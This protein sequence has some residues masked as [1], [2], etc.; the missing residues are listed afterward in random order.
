MYH[1]YA[2]YLTPSGALAKTG[3]TWLGWDIV[4]GCTVPHPVVDDLDIAAMT[5][6]PR[7]YGLHATIKPPMVLAKGRTEAE[8]ILAARDIAETLPQV[9]LKGLRV[10]R[11]GS[12]LAL[13][14]Q[15]ETDGVTQLAAH[16]VERLDPFRDPLRPEDIARR[17]Q[18]HLTASQDQNLMKW[19]YPHVMEDFRFHI[20]LTGPLRNA[21]AMIPVV[22]AHFSSALA[23]PFAIDHL[24]VAGED[25]AG[26]FHSIARLP[27]TQ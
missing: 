4:A 24:T 9:H 5:I 2:I 18:R 21:P 20:T 13:T 15:G 16:V 8:L 7:R 11:L 25:A 26:M 3:A 19:G 14:E 6:R 12:F 27:L 1:R 17:R 10:S 23:V 22:E